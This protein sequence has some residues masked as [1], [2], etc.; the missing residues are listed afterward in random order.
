[1]SASFDLTPVEVRFLDR[2][3][4]HDVAYVAT[5]LVN[6]IATR[7]TEAG[8]D[9]TH[10]RERNDYVRRCASGHQP[11]GLPPTVAALLDRYAPIATVMNDFYFE[12]H[13]TSRLTPYPAA[14]VHEACRESGIELPEIHR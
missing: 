11:A 1:V 6:W 12:L 7:L 3:V 13:G 8:R 14:A 9:W 5:Q 10:P 4:E 2:H